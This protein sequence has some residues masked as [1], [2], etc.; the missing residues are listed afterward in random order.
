MSDAI[1][2]LAMGAL[3]ALDVATTLYV[4][5]KGGQE[6]NPLVAKLIA[7]L[8]PRTALLGV[9]VLAFL[10]LLYCTPY[11]AAPWRYGIVAGYVVLV[12]SNT[13]EA[14]RASRS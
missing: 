1:F 13:R 5:A 11:L 8:G 3:F 2:L 14:W 9:K 4:L 7:G 6:I 10:A 12:L